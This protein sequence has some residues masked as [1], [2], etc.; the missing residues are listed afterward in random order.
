MVLLPEYADKVVPLAIL[1]KELGVDYTVIKH[2][3]D[4]EKGSL[5]V[6]YDWYKGDIAKKILIAAE[7]ISTEDYSVQV[8]WSK[9][10]TGKDRIY[11]RCYGPPLFLQISGSG[12]I[13]PC[14]SFFSP[15]YS[16]Y[17]IGD[18]HNN[19]FKEIWKSEKYW[20]V[21]NFLKSDKF[22]ARKDCASLCLQDK[23]NEKLFNLVEK[24]E[25]LEDLCGKEKPPHVNFI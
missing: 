17:H 12:I 15:E 7:G 9:L 25:R 20:K 5:E 19:S 22:D 21:M 4:D 6:N 24:G 11:S 23:V 16:K 10:K 14:G 18:L 8:K 1:G 13:A 2:C 3:S